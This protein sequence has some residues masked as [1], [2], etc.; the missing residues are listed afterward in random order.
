ML[1]T[2]SGV[3]GI[4]ASE[5]LLV[6]EVRPE[7]EPHVGPWG[8]DHLLS[9]SLLC[10][11]C[12]P[13]TEGC[14]LLVL[15]FNLLAERRGEPGEPCC[16]FTGGQA[17]IGTLLCIPCQD[18][19]VSPWGTGTQV[20]L[21]C[22][23]APLRQMPRAG[24]IQDEGRS[25]GVQ[26]EDAGWEPMWQVDEHMGWQCRRMG[27]KIKPGLCHSHSELVVPEMLPLTSSHG[28]NTNPDSKHLCE[29]PR[30]VPAYWFCISSKQQ[31]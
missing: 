17:G 19:P 15:S 4:E 2:H 14:Q 1:L 8:Q 12:L 29:R 5:A 26:G 25:W 31:L 16:V 28:S 6:G 24:G 9:W 27:V 21:F 20:C 13:A 3:M 11:R 7:G 22:L 18:S 30:G 23:E 10:V